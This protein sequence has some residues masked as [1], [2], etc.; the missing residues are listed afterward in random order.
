MRVRWREFELPNR[1]EFV[2]HTPTYGKLVAEPFER[3]FGTT[4][5]N[6]LRRILLSSIE[7]TA[8]TKVQIEGVQHEYTALDGV[9]EDVLD[10]VLNLK[11]LILRIH[12]R[13]E[14]TLR[15]KVRRKGEVYA[16]DIETDHRCEIVNPELYICT[17]SKEIDLDITL[18]ARRGR[19]YATAEENIDGEHQ[20]GIIPL[21]SVF[22]PIRRV[23]FYTEDTRVG[24]MTDYD[25][26]IMEI[27]TNGTVTPK[28]AI[29]EAAKILRKHM[30]P[31]LQ[32]ADLGEPVHGGEGESLETEEEEEVS[33][34]QEESQLSLSIDALEIR[35]VKKLK[36]A[37][38]QT[39]GDLV[40][41]TREELKTIPQIGDK[42]IEE[43]QEALK[44]R[45]LS[46]KE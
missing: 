44:E 13:D 19:G 39:I 33:S 42:A 38:I 9:L 21:D 6:S 28:M 7:G 41:K 22:S 18:W 23:K 24:E 36:K 30:N 43:I 31:F 40:Q 17:L 4:I 29:V 27:Y 2:E 14:V 8:V 1:M 45:G 3:G 34:P 32:F 12:T 25:R 11:Q 15:L 46:L 5:G 37:G 10:I 20:I 16:R 35:Q 26:L